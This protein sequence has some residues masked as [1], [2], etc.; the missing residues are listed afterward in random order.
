[1]SCPTWQSLCHTKREIRGVFRGVA[2]LHWNPLG[3]SIDTETECLH[4]ISLAEDMGQ[5]ES[6]EMWWQTP[7]Q[8]WLDNCSAKGAALGH[9]DVT[10]V[11]NYHLIFSKCATFLFQLWKVAWVGLNIAVKNVKTPY[12][13]I[14]FR[15]LSLFTNKHFFEKK[16]GMLIVKIVWYWPQILRSMSIKLRRS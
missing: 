1:M 4:K 10:K 15:M 5:W 8:N 3:I 6:S 11:T 13:I 7:S 9:K 12:E 2:W 14:K 16:N